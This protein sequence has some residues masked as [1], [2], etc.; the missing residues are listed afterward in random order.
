M[1]ELDANHNWHYN[2]IDSRNNLDVFNA[3][4]Q[5]IMPAFLGAKTSVGEE[6]DRV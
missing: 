4:C 2:E 5:P 3:K 1:N 6:Q